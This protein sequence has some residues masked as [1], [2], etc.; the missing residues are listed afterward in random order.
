[1]PH[2]FS[3]IGKEDLLDN[4]DLGMEQGYAAI[5]TARWTPLRYFPRT[6]LLMEPVI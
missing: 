5:A 3:I 1:M 4:F 6:R 2:N